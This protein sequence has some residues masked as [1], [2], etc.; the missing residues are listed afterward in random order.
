[1]HVCVFM[2]EQTCIVVV[3]STVHDHHKE[4]STETYLA[5]VVHTAAER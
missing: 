1:M 3:G 5:D 2:S 4:L